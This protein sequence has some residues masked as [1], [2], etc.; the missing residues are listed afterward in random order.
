MMF[1]VHDEL[2][3][4]NPLLSPIL[5]IFSLPST[6]QWIMASCMYAMIQWGT[7]RVSTHWPHVGLN[8][9]Q[10][11]LAAA[12]INE[13]ITPSAKNTLS[14]DKL[15]SE[16]ARILTAEFCNHAPIIAHS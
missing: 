14:T 1:L 2:M 9:T 12:K 15:Q 16:I 7:D 13:L 8:T 5:M 11:E 3:M 10:V 4:V 6:Q